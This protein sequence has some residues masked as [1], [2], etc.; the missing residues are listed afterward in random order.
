VAHEHQIGEELKD[1]AED[2]YNEEFE[3]MDEKHIT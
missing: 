1:K 2:I 3:D